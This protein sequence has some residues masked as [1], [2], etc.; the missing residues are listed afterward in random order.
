MNIIGITH[1]I[2]FNTA[3]AI[4]V[5]G[6]L[7]ATAE[8]ERFNRI[9]YAPRMIPENAVNF[10]LK[11][12]NLKETD[13]DVV[14]TSHNP[15]TSYLNFPINYL[16]G[17]SVNRHTPIHEIFWW[18]ECARMDR[19]LEKYLRTKF[20]NSKIRR[21]SH[22]ISHM[23]SSVLFSGFKDSTFLTLDGRGEFDS[24]LLGE[25]KNNEIDIFH[26][27]KVQESLGI[28]Y[29]EFTSL[30]GF[31]RH[32]DEGKVMGLAPYG[33]PIES[34]SKLVKVDKNY[35]IKINWKELRQINT[36]TLTNDPTKDKRKDLAATAQ[37]L[38]EE[39]ALKLVELLK[40]NSD[41]K[42]ICLAG[43]VALNIDM[44]S[45]ILNSGRFDDIFIQPASSDAGCALG[46]A[47]YVYFKETGKLPQPQMEHAYWGVEY[48][49]EEIENA[50]KRL[51]IKNYTHLDNTQ[52]PA[53]IA[54]LI[55][56]DNIIAWF[57]GR[58]ELG[59]RALGSR[60]FLANPTKAD[61]WK[62][63]NQ[64]KG[65]EYWRPLAPS[66][67]E[68]SIGDLLEMPHDSKFMLLSFKV[69]D[70]KKDLMPATTHVDGTTRPQTVSKSS[71][72]LYWSTIKEFEKITGVPTVINTSL[73]LRGE[74]IV[75]TPEDCVKT[76]FASG[77]D[78]A[79]IGNY[80]LSKT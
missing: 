25:L 45:K 22:H 19:Y 41:S 60:S 17:L 34:L 69:R 55:S 42:N 26:S 44:N 54:D 76:F 40:D 33:K 16:K 8:E 32:M 18:M 28:L 21:V 27:I 12:A 65:R 23:A 48:G 5:D 38:L 11:K 66:M 35:N 56:K 20:P 46:A 71:N 62:I 7:I 64:V 36:G 63:M 9:R 50:L 51:K 49:N 75:N 6:E 79:I 68:E 67:L 73:N 57:Q 61:T 47:A 58:F 78:Y 72:H 29:E 37:Y 15:A 52:I 2:S 80:L 1:P 53:T 74:P 31:R 43:G 4:L 30:T 70:D 3:A 59:P 24:G 39:T 10:V 14:A 13:I 77:T